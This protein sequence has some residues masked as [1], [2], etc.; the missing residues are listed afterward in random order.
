MSA[1][2]H[3]CTNYLEIESESSSR[4]QGVPYLC[5]STLE[6]YSPV[7][8]PFW[9]LFLCVSMVFIEE[10]VIIQEE[11]RRPACPVLLGRESFGTPSQK[12]WN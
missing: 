8:E 10:E 2:A 12:Q 5:R 3:M 4:G 6:Q 9:T 7:K 1:T 11:A